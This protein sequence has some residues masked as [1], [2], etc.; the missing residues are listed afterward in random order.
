M[1]TNVTKSDTPEQD[2][3]FGNELEP[4]IKLKAG[5]RSG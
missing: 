5:S 3:L 4:F 1:V 2:I